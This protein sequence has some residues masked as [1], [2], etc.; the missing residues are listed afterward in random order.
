MLERAPKKTLHP[1]LTCDSPRSVAD[2]DQWGT[3]HHSCEELKINETRLKRAADASGTAL[4]AL[5]LATSAIWS[6]HVA[7]DIFCLPQNGQIRLEQILDRVH[8]DDLDMV[9]EGLDAMMRRGETTSIEY[10]LLLP[11][12]SIRWIHSRGGPHS[13]NGGKSY[14]V[15]GASADVTQR[16]QNEQTLLR[17][18]SFESFLAETSSVFA[19]STLPSDLDHQIEHALWRL[20]DHFHGDRCGLIKVDLEGE[21][22]I[23][24][25]AVYR[26]GLERLPGDVDLVALFPWSFRQLREG[27]CYCFSD[28]AELPVEADR[29]RASWMAMGIRSGL[30]VPLRVENRVHY[31]IVVE[32][33]SGI[34]AGTEDVLNRLQIIGDLFVN[35]L[36]RKATEDEL[37]SSCDE[38]ARL[39]DKL[40]LEADYLRSEVRASRFNDQIVGQSEPIQGVLAMVEQ[41]APTPS[42]V[43]VYGET[44]TGKELVAQ[45]IHNHS[46]R[47]D[48]LMVKVN[49][50]SL[51]SS[52]VESELFG[53][54]RGA[55]TGAL[56]RQMGRF[57]L[58]DGSSLFLDEIA[59]LS[60]ELQSKL[61]RVLQEGEFERLGS[62]RTIK[63]DVR[64]IAATNRNLLEEVRKG[65]F[66]E[67]LYY[68]LSVFPIVV[69]PL[70]ERREDIP[71]LAW[72]FVRDFNEK[73]GKRILRIAKRDMLALQSYSWPGNVR[74][75][76]NVIEYAVIVSPGD[77]L[78]IRLPENI[79]NAPPQMTTLEE[80]ERHYIQDVLRRT[81]WRIKGEGGAA[82]I[83]DLNPATLYSRMKKL[84]I[85]PPR[86]KDGI[87]SSG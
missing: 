17:Q 37:R 82:H 70:R 71:L 1:L 9:R 65:R 40:E 60:L 57:E 75:L 31:L 36:H 33:H 78:K 14:C 66:R 63:V 12:G 48:K 10:R 68:R 87:P 27:R 15:M 52:L 41:V 80:M 34:L 13:C 25:H 56:T 2:D 45:A 73:M 67:D 72:E 58:A 23:I 5:D 74:E 3:T 46:P 55:Y 61:L 47:R 69:P 43:L 83:L 79:V 85:L 26:E 11:D 50:A 77:E 6:N 21:K 16:K 20:L 42:T 53:R 7:R 8:P 51:P 44:G 62:P 38:I 81:E 86:E 4:W 28:L 32:S 76:R 64:V 84:G 49:C 18:L 54:E 30:H 19:K 39:K 35:A 24:T 59:E 22:T 29:D